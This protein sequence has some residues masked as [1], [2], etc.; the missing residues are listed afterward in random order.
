MQL[1]G[2][3]LYTINF[4]I[5]NFGVVSA[6]G[7]RGFAGLALTRNPKLYVFSVERRPIYVGVTKQPMPR[8]L[9]LGWNASGKGGYYG[10]AFRRTLTNAELDVWMQ[11]D[12]NPESSLRDIKT[13]EAEVV[14]LVRAA[15]QWP[16]FQTEIHFYQSDSSHRD[17]AQSITKHFKLDT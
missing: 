4:T 7:S 9:Y 2:P 5:D 1:S 15:R 12:Y 13:V 11:E 3:D 6:E 14:F 17:V 10:Y 8:R 16:E